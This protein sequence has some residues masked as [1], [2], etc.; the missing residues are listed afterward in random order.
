[1]TPPARSTPPGSG[2]AAAAH[3]QPPRTTFKQQAQQLQQKQQ[4][5]GGVA[6]PAASPPPTA[7]PLGIG[8]SVP[9]QRQLALRLQQLEQA[10]PPPSITLEAAFE[11][12]QLERSLA[13]GGSGAPAAPS[14]Q[15]FTRGGLQ[16]LRMA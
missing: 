2:G 16:G 3:L 1:V 9:R 12:M 7:G 6:G 15:L 5:L 8:G 13:A 14:L 10:P 11:R 4:Q